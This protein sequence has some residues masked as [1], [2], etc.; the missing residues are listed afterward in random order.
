MN[1][2]FGQAVLDYHRG[3]RQ[4]VLHLFNSYG[5][6]EE[7]P[8]EVFFEKDFSPLEQLALQQ[9]R[10]RVLDVGAGAG[11]HT[12][13]LQSRGLDVT[14]LEIE[15]QCVQVM[16]GRGVRKAVQHN[17]LGYQGE[18]FDTLL[19]LMNGIGLA[20]TLGKVKGLL[21]HLKKL[22][23]PNGQVLFDSSDL[24]YLFENRQPPQGPPYYG[25]VSFQYF[26]KGVWGPRFEWVY[27]DPS[28][29]QQVALDEGWQ[30]ELLMD[31]GHDLYLARLTNIESIA[32]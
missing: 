24:A 14:A 28:R 26:Y 32:T 15:A 5:E 1:S 22:L 9:C 7:M 23:K 8:V 11:R 19:L 12:L 17:V 29:M 4:H 16:Q 13:A 18:K 6:P 27:V 31:D 3:Q 2:V 30:F 25:Q 21:R 10:G 20:Q